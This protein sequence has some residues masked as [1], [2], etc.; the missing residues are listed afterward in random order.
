[1]NN[2][3]F[4]LLDVNISDDSPVKKLKINLNEDP[5]LIAEEFAKKNDLSEEKTR[6]LIDLIEEKIGEYKIMHTQSSK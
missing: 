4:I 5:K 1:L 6:K 3:Q 2:D